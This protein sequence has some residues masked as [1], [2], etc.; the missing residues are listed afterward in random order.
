[1]IIVDHPSKIK[2]GYIP[3]VDCHACH[4]PCKFSEICDLIDNTTGKVV[5]KEPESI[6]SGDACTVT[7]TPTKPMSCDPFSEYPPLGR[8]IIRDMK[9]TVGLGVIKSVVKKKLFS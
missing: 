8:F 7:L 6:K 9:Q 3:I 4:I 5:E 2:P 1:V